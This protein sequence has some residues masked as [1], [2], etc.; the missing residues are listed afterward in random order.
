M[1]RT[2]SEG[3]FTITLHQRKAKMT[4]RTYGRSPSL[5]AKRER[6]LSNNIIGCTQSLIY[7]TI[8]NRPMNENAL[9]GYV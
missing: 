8:Q 9:R 4:K 2:F 7:R 3:L 5:I 1:L 6:E